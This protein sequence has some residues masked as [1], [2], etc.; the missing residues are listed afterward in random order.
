MIKYNFDTTFREFVIA[1]RDIMF[2]NFSFINNSLASDTSRNVFLQCDT[3]SDVIREYK[4]T[5]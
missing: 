2:Q 1:L 5:S 4:K 3:C